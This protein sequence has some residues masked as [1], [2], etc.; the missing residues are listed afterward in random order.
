MKKTILIL[1]ALVV[2]L[3][4]NVLFAIPPYPPGGGGSVSVS[5][6]AYNET[7]WDGVTAEAPSKNAVRDKIEAMANLDTAGSAG[8][9]KSTATTGK[10]TITGPAAG[11]TRAKT[12]R[13]A[14]DTL[15]ELGGSYTPTGTWNWGS[16]TWTNVPTLNQN[17]TGT[18]AGI[19]AQYI[20][21]NEATGGPSIANKP[22]IPTASSLS[23]DDLITLSGVAEGSVNLGEFTGTTI[24]D[25]LTLK[26]ALQALETALEL[27]ST[28]D[29]VTLSGDP[30]AALFDLT[31]QALSLKTQAANK[32]FAGPASGADAAPGFRDMV[33]DDLPSE[34]SCT[35]SGFYTISGTT[36]GD[37]AGDGT[38]VVDATT[39]GSYA[40]DWF[41]G[42]T[43]LI[44]SG[45]Y[46]GVS[47]TISDFATTTGTVTVSE[48]FA[49]QIVS[50]V[51]YEIRL[52]N[53]PLVANTS[54]EATQG[55]PIFGGPTKPRKYTLPDRD[56]TLIPAT[57]AP[58]IVFDDTKG[59]KAETDSSDDYIAVKV[60][61]DVGGTPAE[62][63][64]VKATNAGTSDAPTVVMGGTTSKAIVQ[65]NAAAD[66]MADDTF[67]GITVVG[68]TYG[69]AVTQWDLVFLASDGKYDQADANAAG[70]F[71]AF[72]VATNAGN[73]TDAAVILVQGIARNEGWTGLT[74]GGK[75]YLGEDS[76]ITQT[77]PSDTGD[78]VQLIG[79]ALSDSEI[80]FCFTPH[81]LEVE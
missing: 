42:G 52:A 6:A 51:T 45:T 22:T 63:E 57:E 76:H 27:L 66:N 9:L 16:A 73:D 58:D 34:I 39:L 70:E 36:D 28:H 1:A 30:I 17:T 49:G 40:N 3:T 64:I 26:A 77:A 25:N 35:L 75:V 4:G 5:D 72:G 33:A 20:D 18:A 31:T 24:D 62:V 43:I 10:M 23:V 59:I 21:W 37:G 78:C 19:A 12:V 15:L 48:A 55:Y 13:D 79:F 2:L 47:K 7:T 67:N 41:N 69:E 81:Y 60:T 44:T 80:Y 65:L 71:P 14:N 68:K 61:D 46:S 38:T 50:G 32:I 29:A 53:T 11:E 56:D 74:V 54:G 8:S